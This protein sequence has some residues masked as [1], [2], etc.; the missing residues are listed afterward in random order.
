[1]RKLRIGLLPKIILAILLGIGFG[2]LFS[3]PFI[4]IF[5]TFNA[6][7]SELLGFS[8]PL[9]ILGLVTVAIA[10]IGKGAGKILLITVLIAYTA[11][12]LSG[13]FAYFTGAAFF[14]SLIEPGV[15]MSDI[16]Q[17]EG[18]QPYFTIAIPPMMSVM[19]ALVLSFVL[20]L[21]L[22]ALDS[23]TLKDAMQDFQVIVT[24]LIA[25][26]IIP[27][28]PLYIFGIFLNMTH[29][30]EVA[31]VLT[32]FLS[33]I[34]II[35]GLHIL[36]LIFQY[37][38]AGMIA[39]KNPFRM[40]W[41]MMPAYFTALGTQ[42][43]AATIPVT[44]RS[45]INCGVREEIAGF[46][47]PLCATIHLSGSTLKI[48]CCALALMIMQGMP[49]DTGNFI[50]FIFMLG[51]TMVAAPGVPGG[52]I[53]AA[54]GILHSILG[55]DESMQA[56]MIALYIAMDNFGTACNVTGDGAI[57]LI[58]DKLMRPKEAVA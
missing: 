8:I 39:K 55:F 56:L 49:I 48:T 23:R 34:G 11:T 37:S 18:V 1:M 24:Q 51:I 5:V 54:L 19:T 53:M 30:G 42:S 4:R 2:N 36:L 28:L 17:A 43:S 41:R 6:I 20:G 45:A 38:V 46:T 27:L 29:Q 40:L 9:I 15:G 32:V 50:G 33:I 31:K 22:A 12:I 21:G 16:T 52:A 26:V 58:V 25:K 44:L 47:I 35:F 3:F 57:S 10:D 14:P 13:L 7:F